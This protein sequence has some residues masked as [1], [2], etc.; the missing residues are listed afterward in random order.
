MSRQAGLR[1]GTVKGD[2]DGQGRLLVNFHGFPNGPESAWAPVVTPLAGPSRGAFFMPEPGDE[3]M[4]AFEQGDFDHPYIIGFV[5]DGVHHP[6]ETD[7]HN[8]VIVTPGKHELRFEDAEGSKKIVI[9]SSGGHTVTLDDSTG[10]EK[11]VVKSNSGH[12]IT[13]NELTKTVSIVTAMGQSLTM[14]DLA[15]TTILMGGGVTLTMAAGSLAI[16]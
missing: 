4:V 8:R 11:V 13:L 9:K 3:V 14:N 1:V 7:R 15:Q 2:P 12:S 16:T 10:Q 6:P 5:W